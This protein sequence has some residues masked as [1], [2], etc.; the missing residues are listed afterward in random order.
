MQLQNFAAVSQLMTSEQI[1]QKQ[2]LARDWAAEDGYAAHQ[3]VTTRLRYGC[4]D[5]LPNR[6][7]QGRKLHWV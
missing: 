6:D 7:M 1:A 4:P 3:H 2:K 5:R